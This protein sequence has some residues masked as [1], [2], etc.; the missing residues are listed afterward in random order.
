MLPKIIDYDTDTKQIQLTE[1][2]YVIPELRNLIDKYPDNYV[3]Y[4]TY[5][6]LMCGYNSP[7]INLPDSERQEQ[8]IFD[9][10]ELFTDFDPFEP[11]L[12]KAVEKLSDLYKSPIMKLAEELGNEVDRF[13]KILKTEAI[14]TGP[15]GNFRERM[16]L[17]EKI[18]KISSSYAKVKEQAKKEMDDDGIRGDH[19]IGMY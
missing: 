11:L 10:Q 5:V 13:R 15:E 6:Y 14:V 19:E 3:P 12:E 17:L 16:A 2:A 8:V 1:N 7:Y 4:V 9:V 18:D